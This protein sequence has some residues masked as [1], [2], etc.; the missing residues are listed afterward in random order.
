VQDKTLACKD[1][2]KDFSFTVRDQQFYAEKGFENE[3]QRC[4]DC[5]LQR[6]TRV[7]PGGARE[8]HEAVCAQCSA[9]TTVPFRPRGDRPV[10][11][12][13]CYTAMT[14]QAASG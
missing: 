12:R 7:Q 5:R 11:C 2:G 9:Q 10:Y 14:P 4:R 13:T 1:C 6:K 3:P 8:M